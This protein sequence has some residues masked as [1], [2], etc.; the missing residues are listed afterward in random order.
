M[1]QL[2]SKASV[3]GIGAVALTIGSAP[4]AGA[5]DGVTTKV[6][7]T[8]IVGGVRMPAG[9]YEVRAMTGGGGVLAITSEDGRH[10]ALVAT[11]DGPPAKD[12]ES[13]AE[14]TFEKFQNQYFLAGVANDEG[15]DR[16]IPLTLKAMRRAIAR[17]TDRAHQ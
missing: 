17:T 13:P 8:F 4:A 2:I 10:V 12:L 9:M 3:V 15:S 7:F 6:P 16:E 14:L 1:R 11:I 5:W